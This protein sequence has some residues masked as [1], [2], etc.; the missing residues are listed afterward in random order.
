MELRV[1]VGIMHHTNAVP[2]LAGLNM[3]GDVMSD[4]PNIIGGSQMTWM[5]AIVLACI[6]GVGLVMLIG[7]LSLYDEASAGTLAGASFVFPKG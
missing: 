1:H 2:I 7:L 5:A 4:D 6:L 3:N